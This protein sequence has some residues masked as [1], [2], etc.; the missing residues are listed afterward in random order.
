MGQYKLMKNYSNRLIILTSILI[1]LSTTL[2]FNLA[3]FGL[4]TYGEEFVEESVSVDKCGSGGLGQCYDGL[5]C[6]DGLTPI[7][8]NNCPGN[9]VDNP[10]VCCREKRY[11]CS[12]STFKCKEQIGGQYETNDSCKESCVARYSCKDPATQKCVAVLDGDYETL[13]EC[14]EE[15]TNRYSCIETLDYYEGIITYECEKKRNGTFS[16]EAN[17]EKVCD[18]KLPIPIPKKEVE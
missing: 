8:P 6:G 7:G 11:S 4:P 3:S 18:K 9:N 17:C 10:R 12:S 13:K 15:C 5:K 2:V 16:S 14:N 1:S